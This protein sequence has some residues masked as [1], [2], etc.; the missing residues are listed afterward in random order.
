MDSVRGQGAGR[1]AE[2]AK[3]KCKGGRRDEPSGEKSL[4]PA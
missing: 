1:I 3:G 4:K 2:K